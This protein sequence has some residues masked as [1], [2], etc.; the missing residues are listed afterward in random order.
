MSLGTK[1]DP[2]EPFLGGQNIPLYSPYQLANVSGNIQCTLHDKISKSV[3]NGM[4]ENGSY[5]FAK[6]AWEILGK[7]LGAKSFPGDMSNDEESNCDQLLDNE[8]E[9]WRL[10][11]WEGNR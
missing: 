9:E 6:C 5:G 4:V 11:F 1:W 2:F 3:I 8:S 10:K 7:V